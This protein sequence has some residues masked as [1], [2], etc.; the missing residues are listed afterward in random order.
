[1]SIFCYTFFL[2]AIELTE[3]LGVLDKQADEQRKKLIHHAAE[4]KPR[5]S[6]SDADT[7][8]P[9]NP[10]KWAVSKEWQKGILHLILLDRMHCDV[11]FPAGDDN[12]E[13]GQVSVPEMNLSGS[14]SAENE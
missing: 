14:E 8:P 12:G 9:E 13:H 10:P 11:N 6:G 7:D 2:I 1:M 3:F 5:R 4:R